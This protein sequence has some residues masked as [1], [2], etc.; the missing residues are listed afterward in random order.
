ME[1]RLTWLALFLAA[2]IAAAQEPPEIVRTWCN[3]QDPRT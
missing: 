1:K 2:G 3:D